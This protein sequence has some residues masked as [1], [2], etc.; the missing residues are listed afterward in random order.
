VLA[1]YIGKEGVYITYGSYIGW[2]RIKRNRCGDSIQLERCM[3]IAYSDTSP[4]YSL[5]LKL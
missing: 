1:R 4:F 2:Y 5:I 3:C